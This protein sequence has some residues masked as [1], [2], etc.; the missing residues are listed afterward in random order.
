[1]FSRRVRHPARWLMILANYGVRTYQVSDVTEEHSFSDYQINRLI[2]CAFMVL[3]GVAY[4]HG[5]RL[6]EPDV[7]HQLGRVPL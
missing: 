3:V 7:H 1:M 6:R 4:W 5:E 2:T